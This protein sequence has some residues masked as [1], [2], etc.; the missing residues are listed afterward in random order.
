M[1]EHQHEQEALLQAWMQMSVCIRGNRILSGLSFNE[2]ML[3]GMLYRDAA[4]LTAT[5]VG[6]RMRLLKSQVNH[7]L[8]TLEKRGLLT[9]ARSTRDKRVIHVFLTEEGRQVY[10]AEHARV[11]EIMGLIR[12]ELG[13][14]NTRQLTDLITRATNLVTTYTER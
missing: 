12:Q 8:T 4:P 14:D 6:E 3:C 13:G 2:I 11:L 10:E 9:R 7:I 1:T 5:E